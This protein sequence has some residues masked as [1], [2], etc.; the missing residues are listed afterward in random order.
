MSIG[1]YETTNVGRLK[2]VNVFVHEQVFDFV[3]EGD[4]KE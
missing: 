3:Y 4:K 1:D 2:R